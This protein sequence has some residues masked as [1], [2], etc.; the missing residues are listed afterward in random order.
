[1]ASSNDVKSAKDLKAKLISFSND[2]LSDN[3]KAF[4]EAYGDLLRDLQH[5]FGSMNPT[6]VVSMANMAVQERSRI[7]RLSASR[8]VS[9]VAKKS[10]PKK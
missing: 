7:D 6:P 3:P 5:D 10:V 2:H 1:L 8:R 4:K 9:K